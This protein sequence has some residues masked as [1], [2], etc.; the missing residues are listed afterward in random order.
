MTQSILKTLFI[1][2]LAASMFALTACH[3]DDDPAPSAL[4]DTKVF[5]SQ[6][7][8]FSDDPAQPKVTVTIPPGAL[9]E[10]AQLTVKKVADAGT[11]FHSSQYQITLTTP[12]KAGVSLNQA[13]KIALLSDAAPTHPEL[14]EIVSQADTT[15]TR[16]PAS[17]YR[18]STQTVVSM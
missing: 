16:L 5:A 18:P 6:G 15:P 11:G 10:D 17:F 4:V 14:A 13:M 1:L 9:S 3:D 12:T 7:G 8:S 2:V